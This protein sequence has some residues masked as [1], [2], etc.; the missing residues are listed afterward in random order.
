MN[1]HVGIIAFFFALILSSHGAPAKTIPLRPNRTQMETRSPKKKAASSQHSTKLRTLSHNFPKRKTPHPFSV[2]TRKITLESKMGNWKRSRTKNN[3][4]QRCW[5]QINSDEP[6]GILS[7]V[8]NIKPSVAGRLG[9]A[10]YE[11]EYKIVRSG[12]LQRF[13]HGQCTAIFIKQ[14]DS[15]LIRHEHCSTANPTPFFLT[16]R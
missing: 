8:M 2:S 11:Y 5:T 12:V 16:P 13:S 7:K 3:T 9:W 4:S 1:L 15:W 10:T 6:I 14:V